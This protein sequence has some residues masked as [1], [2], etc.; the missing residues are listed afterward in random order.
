M[1]AISKKLPTICRRSDDVT[2]Q[3]DGYLAR[4]EIVGFSDRRENRYLQLTLRDVEAIVDGS[5]GNFKKRFESGHMGNR[6]RALRTPQGHSKGAGV[7]SEYLKKITEPGMLVHGATLEN[8]KRICSDGLS[9]VDRLH[10]HLGSMLDSRPVGIRHGSEVSIVVGGNRCISDGVISYESANRVM[11]TEGFNGVIPPDYI[12][13]AYMLGSGRILFT[14]PGG[15]LGD[16]PKE[17][18]R[19]D[20]S[21]SWDGAE[22]P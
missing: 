7:T 8:A 20:D 9:R 13:Q 6:E 19:Y 17:K 10:I 12:A 18:Q 1:T 2:R 14:R 3:R 16:S 15:R 22:S 4:G 21:P 5:G 11:P